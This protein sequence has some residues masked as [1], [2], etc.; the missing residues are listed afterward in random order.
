MSPTFTVMGGDWLPCTVALSYR[1]GE[2]G[3]FSKSLRGFA[4]RRHFTEFPATFPVTDPAAAGAPISDF[5]FV[6]CYPVQG[7]PPV[8]Q[9]NGEWIV[10]TPYVFDNHFVDMATIGTFETYLA[11]FSSKSRSTLLRKVRKFQ[12]VSGGNL[13]W[14]IYSRPEQFDEFFSLAGPLSATTY[15]ARLLNSGLPTDPRFVSTAKQRAASGDALGFVLFL[16]GN[17]VAY[18]FCFRTNG[19]VTYD[20]VGF[21]ASRAD[22]SPGTVL[23]FL[24][25]QFLFSDGRSRIFDFTEGEGGHKRLFGRSSLHCAKSYILKDSLGNRLL[26]RSHAVL[27]RSVESIGRWLDRIGLKNRV[28]AVIRRSA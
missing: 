27:N 22:L 1:L 5:Y 16:E 21:D 12:E 8:I 6:P 24:I 13:D 14:R 4:L 19:I 17:A 20:Y 23:Q 10:Y 9:R 3:L 7:E 11:Q 15:Q 2:I 28:R 26:L 25:L 18:V